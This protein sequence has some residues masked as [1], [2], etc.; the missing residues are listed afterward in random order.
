MVEQT[1]Y[2]PGSCNIGSDEIKRRYTIGYSGIFLIIVFILFI[3]LLHLPRV[4]RLGLFVPAFYTFSG[5][6][7]G[8]NKFCFV[9]GW[10]GIASLAGRRKFISVSDKINLK[11][12]RM[13]AIRIVTI[14][15]IFSAILTTLYFIFPFK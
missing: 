6:V 4:Y 14:V 13:M 3:E 11:R 9:Y 8:Y 12:D 5:F 15:S 1:Q 2:K 10:K 7:Q